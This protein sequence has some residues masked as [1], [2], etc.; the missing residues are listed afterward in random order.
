L[1][2][3]QNEAKAASLYKLSAEQGCGDALY[4]LAVFFEHGMG[5]KSSKDFTFYYGLQCD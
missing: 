2:V 5:G 3:V 1:G 4:N